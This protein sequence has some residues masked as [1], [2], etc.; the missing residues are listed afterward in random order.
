MD[1]EYVEVFHEVFN[2]TREFRKEAISLW[3]EPFLKLGS[4]PGAWQNYLLTR[5]KKHRKKWRYLHNRLALEGTISVT[6]HNG[7]ENLLPIM[8]EYQELEQK[9]GKKYWTPRKLKKINDLYLELATALRPRGNIHIVFLRLNRIPIAGIIGMSFN[10]RYAALRTVFD[11]AFS[12]YSPGFLVGGHDVKWAIENG[13]SEYDFMSS[14]LTDKLLW[15]DS[16]RRSCILRVV[17]KG[18]WAGLFYSTK[19]RI[20]PVVLSLINQTG[21]DGRLGNLVRHDRTVVATSKFSKHN[22]RLQDSNSG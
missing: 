7:E 14:F 20:T 1:P 13:F 18:A 6:R 16:Y 15:T 5:S 11:D 4:G 19:F 3:V 21:W 10:E 9:S 12:K 2:N 17:R 8:A 22:L